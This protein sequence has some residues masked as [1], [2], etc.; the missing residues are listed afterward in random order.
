MRKREFVECPVTS[1]GPWRALLRD[2]RF[3]R[4][5][6]I[7][8]FDAFALRQESA[9]LTHNAEGTLLFGV[10]LAR[11]RWHDNPQNQSVWLSL[12][13]SS[14]VFSPTHTRTIS[15]P[16]FSIFIMQLACS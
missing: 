8:H 11:F 5:I 10:V 6:C 16:S 2:V 13:S 15:S 12:G 1:L 7:F 9:H 3:C 14:I 4:Q